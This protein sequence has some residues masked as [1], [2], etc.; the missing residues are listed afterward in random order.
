MLLAPGQSGIWWEI[1]RDDIAANVD[2]HAR[3][4]AG[5]A[6]DEFVKGAGNIRGYEAG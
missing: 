1:G 4:K 6:S 2:V 5:R 3:I